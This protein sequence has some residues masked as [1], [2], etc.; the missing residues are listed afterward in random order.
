VL[1][2]LLAGMQLLRLLRG[3]HTK[4]ANAARMRLKQQQQQQQQVL[5]IMLTSGSAC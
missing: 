3:S 2:Q 1:L 4:A 5:M